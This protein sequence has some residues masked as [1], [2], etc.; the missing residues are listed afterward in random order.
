[1]LF[2][3][4]EGCFSLALWKMMIYDEFYTSM[5]VRIALAKMKVL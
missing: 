2:R 1:M 3:V 4:D 5:R